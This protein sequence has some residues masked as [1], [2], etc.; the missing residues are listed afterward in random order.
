MF[1]ASS[2]MQEGRGPS[3]LSLSLV[4]AVTWKLSSTEGAGAPCTRLRPRLC[5]LPVSQN[6]QTTLPC[7]PFWFHVAE[8]E[9]EAPDSRPA[10]WGWSSPGGPGLPL[11]V[12][13]IIRNRVPS[14]RVTCRPRLWIRRAATE[15]AHVCFQLVCGQLHPRGIVVGPAKTIHP[16]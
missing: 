12:P 9:T 3:W 1:P 10:S 8:E 2:G 7:P 11:C 13:C 5:V 16:K 4:P 14:W 15:G 6:L